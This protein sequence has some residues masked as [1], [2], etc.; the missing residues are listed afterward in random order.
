MKIYSVAEIARITNQAERTIYS[1]IARGWLQSSTETEG[2]SRQ[3]FTEID[4]KRYL[5]MRAK[6]RYKWDNGRQVL[7]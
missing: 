6:L 7:S 4:V 3:I 1:H 2:R 5:L